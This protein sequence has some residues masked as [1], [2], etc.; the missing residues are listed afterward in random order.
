MSVVYYTDGHRYQLEREYYHWTPYRG[1]AGGNDFVWLDES[2]L[3]GL[4]RGYA[5]D[6]ASGPA[7][8]T[9]N[10][11]RASLV[12]DSLYQLIRLGILDKDTDRKVADQLLRD[13]AKEDGMSSF[14]AA[15][16]YAAVRLFGGRYMESVE[17]NVLTAP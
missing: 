16:V 7:I 15:Y 11:V 10:F 3:L 12:H 13:I 5:W 14:R 6:G 8:N 1:K 4:S 9:K 2:G 17:H